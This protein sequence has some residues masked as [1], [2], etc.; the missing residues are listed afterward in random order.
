MGV[1][2]NALRGETR[3]GEWDRANADVHV[4]RGDRGEWGRGWMGYRK[5][6]EAGLRERVEKCLGEV[7]KEGVRLERDIGVYT[8]SRYFPS[9]FIWSLFK[10]LNCSPILE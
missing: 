3:R 2:I 10:G 5:L 4:D 9:R 6:L 8:H 1:L 7:E